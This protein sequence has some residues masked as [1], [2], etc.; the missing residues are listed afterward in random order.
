[1]NKLSSLDDDTSDSL[2]VDMALSKSGGKCTSRIAADTNTITTNIK[3][4]HSG[5]KAI[6]YIMSLS[7]ENCNDICSTVCNDKNK[8]SSR[9]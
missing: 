5:F 2:D 8:Q 6:R 3:N 9:F 4:D 7:T 1:M